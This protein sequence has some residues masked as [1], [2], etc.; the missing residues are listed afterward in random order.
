MKRF[1]C[2]IIG[3]IFFISVSSVFAIQ[4][5]SLMNEANQLYQDKQ[6]EEAIVKYVSILE[7]DTQTLRVLDDRQ[8]AFLV[9]MG[10]KGEQVTG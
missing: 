3:A 2:L 8:N 5:E 10:Q 1:L 9:Q 7:T 6:Y 4:A